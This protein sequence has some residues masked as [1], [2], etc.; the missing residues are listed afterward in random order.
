MCCFRAVLAKLDKELRANDAALRYDKL[1]RV[2]GDPDRLMEVFENLLHNALRHRGPDPP[3]IQ[4][5]VE[6]RAE[7]WLFAVRDN[8]PGVPARLPGEHLP[9]IRA[10]AWQSARQVRVWVWRFAG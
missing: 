4:V 7:E 5:T 8:G 3:Q 1:P 6:R 9:A 2:F 10:L